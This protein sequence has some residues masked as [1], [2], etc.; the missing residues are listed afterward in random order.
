M[1]QLELGL[2]TV[3]EVQKTLEKC[4]K[5]ATAISGLYIESSKEKISFTLAAKKGI[6]D[7]SIAFE[8]LEAQV[9]T[10]FII[11][12][13][14]GKTYSAEEAIA[15]GLID[16]EFKEKLLDAE[17]AVLGY[18][19][20][21]KKLSVFQAI[22]ARLLERQKGKRILEAQIA[23]GG[24][25]D[26]IRSIRIPAEIAVLK[27]LLNHTSLKFL[28]EPASNVKGF[29]FPTNKQ[30]MY[31]SELLEMSVLDLESKTYLLPI[32][33]RNITAF[34]ADK[35]H[36]I[37]IVDLR[38]GSEFTR[39]EAYGRGL[40]DQ[41]VYFELSQQ[42]CLWE[43]SSVFDS[44]GSSQTL[45]TDKKSGRQFIIDEAVSKGLIDRTQFSK[46]KEGQLSPTELADILVNRTRPS[47]DPY[48]PV[49]GYWL[50][51]TNERVSLFK[52]LRRNMVDRVTVFRCLEA[53]AS[54]GG[55]VDP[56]NGKKYNVAQALQKGLIDEVCAKQIQQCELAFIGVPQSISKGVITVAEAMDKNLFNK[57]IGYR[58]LEYQ[59]VT[60]GLIDP[61][62]NSRLSLEEAIRKGVVDAATAT[63]LKDEKSYAKTLTCPKTRR[64]L[65]YKDAVD[66][67]VY[68]CHTGLRLVE[69]PLPRNFGIPSLYFSSQ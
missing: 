15:N 32:G 10:G 34:S 9:V 13:S 67:A 5:K 55:I 1:E 41:K 22:E 29:H 2:T 63:K 40:I 45:L 12:P 46:F 61:R 60:G 25:I 54:T 38:S 26:P 7:R 23:T 11:D 19:H 49:A 58:C 3:Q 6:I 44:N 24:V 42:E 30:N 14:T 39:L 8:F 33:E 16:Q 66:K 65:S 59:Y 52:A 27:G 18:I 62:S 68:D 31:Y 47:K 56:S 43:T 48:S 36:K 35:G 4:L 17:K 37:C 69:A 20:S 53:Q 50:Y 57:E 28:H 64:K 21:G 51:E